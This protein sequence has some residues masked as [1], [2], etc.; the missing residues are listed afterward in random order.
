[1]KTAYINSL[2]NL[3]NLDWFKLKVLADNKDDPND[4]IHSLQ[5]EK[6]CGKKKRCW[7]TVFS[8]FP[9]MFSKVFFLRIVQSI[10]TQ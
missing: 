3:K 10:P 9:K 7:L 8:P 1:M 6:H 4:K 2:P 5:V